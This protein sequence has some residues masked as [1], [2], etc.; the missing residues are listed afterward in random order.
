MTYVQ[1]SISSLDL[2]NLVT[3]ED[4]SFVIS[5]EQ[6]VSLAT[7][8]RSIPTTHRLRADA[9]MVER[10]GN[11][12]RQFA[13]S[14]VTARRTIGNAALRRGGEVSSLL[15]AIHD[16]VDEHL[17]RAAKGYAR[18]GTLGH[19]LAQQTSPVLAIVTAEAM[20]WGTT[21]LETLE[22]F[23]TPFS[24]AH[25]D[26]Y[27]DVAGARTSLRGRRDALIATKNGRIVVRLRTGIPSPTAVAGLRADLTIDA[28][29]NVEGC[30]AQRIV[31][32]WPDAGIALAVD[33]GESVIRAGARDL[34]RVAITQFRQHS[35][36]AA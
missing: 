6:R 34:L 28:F 19:W 17:F 29:A 12:G 22:S 36:V 32:V 1:R 24:I 23:G 4:D 30:A 15:S 2:S 9:W 35:S 31:G 26:A 10:R 27:Y 18:H 3:C 33:G 21:A 14:P 20:T 5:D 7:R 13:W 11:T 16:V 25:S 8:F